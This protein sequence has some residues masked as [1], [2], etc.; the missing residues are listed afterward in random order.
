M[1]LFNT[2]NLPKVIVRLYK[3]QSL[4]NRYHASKYKRDL[5]QQKK[6][7]E[8]KTSQYQHIIDTTDWESFSTISSPPDEETLFKNYYHVYIYKKITS[9]CDPETKKSG[10]TVVELDLDENLSH[11]SNIC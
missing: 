1:K 2:G 10:K 7:V 6:F 8:E 5:L 4:V 3:V 11:T 9:I